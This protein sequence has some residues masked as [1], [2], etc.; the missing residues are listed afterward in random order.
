MTPFGIVC[1]VGFILL[2]V[3]IAA[4]GVMKYAFGISLKTASSPLRGAVMA[5]LSGKTQANA[6]LSS[7]MKELAGT[8][9]KT[10]AG[11]WIVTIVLAVFVGA[12]LISM[13]VM[14]WDFETPTNIKN[15]AN[16]A[17]SA[18]SA[19]ANTP[20][21]TM[22][23]TIQIVKNT[24]GANAALLTNFYIST[25]NLAGLGY[26]KDKGGNNRAVYNKD[27]VRLSLLGGAR[28]FVLECW[29]NSTGAPV[30]QIVES[31][32]MWRRTS[33]NSVP[34]ATV[35][36]DL[37]TYAFPAGAQATE[38]IIVYL[39]FRTKDGKDPAPTTMNLAANALQ[40]TIQP[41]R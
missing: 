37:M 22:A 19:Y 21:K 14:R 25:A 16:D 30:V 35:L 18:Y 8:S 7:K 33:W 13:I 32:S 17:A 3:F 2:L 31:G 27:I 23:E 9:F 28:A 6:F 12:Y 34:L 11:H 41:Y 36:S 24:K 20:R 40:S 15:K 29:P 26:S 5:E 39:R 38:L 4:W 10:L 1:L